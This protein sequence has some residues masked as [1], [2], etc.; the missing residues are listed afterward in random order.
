MK[1]SRPLVVLRNV[2]GFAAMV[3]VCGAAQAAVLYVFN[4]V[5]PGIERGFVIVAVVV[6]CGV[7]GHFLFGGAAAL[8]TW[9]VF[10]SVIVFG[11]LMVV[12][13]DPGRTFLPLLNSIPLAAM[14]AGAARWTA[15]HLE[16]RRSRPPP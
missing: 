13:N 3:A 1:S 8:R 6:L 14:A 15:M 2:A 11:A 5:G 10:L 7:I 4:F 12:F 16:S 9:L